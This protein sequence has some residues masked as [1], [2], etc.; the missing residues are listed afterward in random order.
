M[1][2]SSIS[3][4]SLSKS[5]L[6]FFCPYS[7]FVN[8]AGSDPKIEDL[9]QAMS[10]ASPQNTSHRDGRWSISAKRVAWPLE[11]QKTPEF[12]GFFGVAS[13]KMCNLGAGGRTR[14]GTPSLAVDFESTTSTNSITPANYLHILIHFSENCKRYFGK[15]QNYFLD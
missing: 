6:F 10:L 2:G 3:L 11:R 14:T 8:H 5:I 1:G 9:P 4:W 7:L 15:F 12:R 13:F